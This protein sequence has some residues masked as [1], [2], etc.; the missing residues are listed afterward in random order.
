MITEKLLLDIFE[1]MKSLLHFKEDIFPKRD[2]R[3][4]GICVHLYT[5][6]DG[7]KEDCYMMTYNLKRFKD[8]ADI[9]IAIAHELGH[10]RKKH[11]TTDSYLSLVEKEYQAESFALDVIKKYYNAY[12]LRAIDSLTSYINGNCKVYSEAFQKL[13]DERLGDI[14]EEKRQKKTQQNKRR[15]RK[16]I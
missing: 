8:K 9:L 13:Y 7:D 12:Y 11:L 16:R 5:Y 2:N 4:K 6:T 1:E 15:I 14:F 10:I 3:I